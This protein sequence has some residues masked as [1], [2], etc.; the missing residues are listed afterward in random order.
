MRFSDQIDLGNGALRNWQAESERLLFDQSARSRWGRGSTERERER[1]SLCRLLDRPG[2]APSSRLFCARD[3]C[4]AVT[5]YSYSSN[6]L[7][8]PH[9]EDLLLSVEGSIIVRLGRGVQS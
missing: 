8:P 4:S 5:P 3:A 9:R 7:S 6:T 2:D 1:V